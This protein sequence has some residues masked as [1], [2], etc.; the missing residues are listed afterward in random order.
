MRRD[1]GRIAVWLASASAVAAAA[2]WGI[3]ARIEARGPVPLAEAECLALLGGGDCG[4]GQADCGCTGEPCGALGDCN[5]TSTSCNKVGNACYKIVTTAMTRCGQ[6][7]TSFP[8][9]CSQ[10]VDPDQRC[11]QEWYSTV[12]AY[13]NDC[14]YPFG[15]CNLGPT[16][17]G[18][19][20]TTCTQL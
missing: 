2:S 15:T 4:Q 12:P 5:T 11:A 16:P 17:C 7:N 8:N 14:S 19:N 20:M 10:L 18:A 9:G 1:L 13:Y 3:A 6:T